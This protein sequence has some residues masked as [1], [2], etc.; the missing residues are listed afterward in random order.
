MLEQYGPYCVENKNGVF[1][2]TEEGNMLVK[3]ASF[4]RK[5]CMQYIVSLLDTA[6]TA[7]RVEAQHLSLELNHA[8]SDT[9]LE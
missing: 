2:V 7:A 5:D 3:H 1:Y 6:A 9:N 4:V 8:I